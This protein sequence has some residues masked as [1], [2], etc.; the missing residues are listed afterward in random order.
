MAS[1][2]TN[3]MKLFRLQSVLVGFCDDVG[4][5]FRSLNGISSIDRYQENPRSLY[6]T[7]EI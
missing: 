6:I 3:L 1:D 2:P 7:A 4:E 5:L